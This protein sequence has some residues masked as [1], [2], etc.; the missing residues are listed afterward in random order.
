MLLAPVLAFASLESG[1]RLAGYGHDLAARRAVRASQRVPG[2]EF[3]TGELNITNE[4]CLWS[5]RPGAQPAPGEFVNAE[6][7]RG[8]LVPDTR[9]EGVARVLVL[10]E[11]ALFGYRLPYADTLVGRLPAL[12][13]EHGVQAEVI[14]AAVNGQTVWQGHARYVH[15]L[16]GKQP[17]VVVAAFGT[18]NEH[19]VAECSDEARLAELRGAHGLLASTAR[20]LRQHSRSVLLFESLCGSESE[21]LSIDPDSEKP[22]YLRRVGS[23]EFPG[24]RRVSLESFR[25][26]LTALT[27]AVTDDGIPLLLISMP[28][29]P[30]AEEFA[31]VLEA[32]TE[33][34]TDV[35]SALH[36]PVVPARERL[37]EAA[38]DNESA[39]AYFLPGD[40][41]HPS[42]RGHRFVA[43]LLAEPL[44]E[45]LQQR[46]P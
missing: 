2:A 28:R 37:A 36:V 3:G 41:F 12:L 16:R 32:Y 15:E 33:A 24:L 31:P 23:L 19:R 46:G 8:P 42:A 21:V 30:Y 11:S 13:A 1:L 6:G 9:R 5:L 14:N 39:R 29:M 44:A 27:Q 40:G 17:D 35:A 4:F 20:A 38:P 7:L 22:G 26:G 43:E 45:A 25:R 18:V 34:L 10:G